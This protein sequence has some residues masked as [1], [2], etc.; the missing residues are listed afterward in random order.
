[1]EFT[2]V[3]QNMNV[4]TSSAE[5]MLNGGLQGFVLLFED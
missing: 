2:V 3:R 4:A 5:F 1:M